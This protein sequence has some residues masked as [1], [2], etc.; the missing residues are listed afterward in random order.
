[1]PIRRATPADVSRIAE[2]I[3]FN[4]R[5]NFFPIFQ[6]EGFSFGEM[7]VLPLANAYLADPEKIRDTRVYDDGVIKGLTIVKGREIEKLYVEPAFQGRG[8]G[9]MLL[10]HAVSALGAR[11]LWAL[12]K[13]ESALRFY[14]RHGFA[15]TGERKLEEGTTEYLVKLERHQ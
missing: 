11:F 3:V 10:D 13:N 4:N 12:E 7:Q 2:I 8:I 6:D 14:A 15:P 9:A 1:M 5:L